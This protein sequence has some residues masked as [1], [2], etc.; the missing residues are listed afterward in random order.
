M[1]TIRNDNATTDKNDTTTIHHD[2]GST[3]RTNESSNTAESHSFEILDSHSDIAHHITSDTSSPLDTL[4]R[5]QDVP[6]PEISDVDDTV[7]STPPRVTT[8]SLS[9]M[10]FG[11]PEDLVPISS[12]FQPH[13]EYL[14]QT[15]PDVKPIINGVFPAG[16]PHFIYT[17]V[18]GQKRYGLL[19]DPG[20]S[21]G[22]IGSETLR[23]IIDHVLK[24]RKM[25]SLVVWTRSSAKF[26]G[27]SSKHEESLSMVS[28]PIGLDGIPNA[29]FSADVIG[30]SACTCPGLIPL[31]TL[32]KAGC[33][34]SCGYFGNG[35]GILGIRAANGFHAQ[36]LL[37]TDSGHYL[38]P[39]DHFDHKPNH[40]M[41]KCIAAEEKQIAKHK[42]RSSSV[43]D[44][45]LLSGPST[46]Q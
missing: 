38:L 37:L 10:L 18:R 22:L 14:P 6:N 15:H 25:Q 8:L 16:K 23:E 12:P 1:T 42:P 24:P 11:S 27:I 30:G 31:H 41:D 46:F 9:T 39:V 17:C 32:S 45:A 2:L 44:C 40:K 33:I 34:I 43:P 19:V 3:L 29:T 13:D 36:R 28:F 7:E 20:A 35:D 21:R 5:P 4:P 26:S